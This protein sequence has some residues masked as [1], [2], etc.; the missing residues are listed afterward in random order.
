MTDYGLPILATLA[1]WWGSHR[2]DLLSRQPCRRTF[3]TSMAGASRARALRFGVCRGDLGRN[4]SGRGLRRLRYGLIALG[5]ATRQLSTPASSPGR[6]RPPAP[7]NAGLSRFVRGGA[8]EPLSRDVRARS[9]RSLLLAITHGRPNMLGFW[10]YVLWW[11]HESAKLNVFFGVPNLGEEMLPEHLRYLDELHDAPADEHVL[12]VLG[13]DCD[14]C[15]NP[16]FRRAAQADA[17]PFEA[18]ASRCSPP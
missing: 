12:P 6:A 7:R 14:H 15:C 4:D 2:R 1:L 10:T 13:D 11:M 8:H 16:L 5:L 17:T 3:V 18:T 9:A